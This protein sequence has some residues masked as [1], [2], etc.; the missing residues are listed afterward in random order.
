MIDKSLLISSA[1]AAG[2]KIDAATAEKFDLYARMLVEKNEHVNLTAITEPTEIVQK[3][4]LDSI[5]PLCALEIPQGARVVDV[6]TGAG[7][8]GIPIKLIRPDIELILL[9]SLNKRVEVLKEF[10]E[11]LELTGVTFV[12]A[13]AEDAARGELRESCDVALSR[14]VARLNKLCEYCLPFVKPGGA[15]AALKGPTADEEAKEAASAV[16]L[17]GGRLRPAVSLDIP[18]TALTHRL[19]IVDKI[20]PTPNKYPRQSGQIAKNAL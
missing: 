8:P 3:H 10:C 13:R 9:D 19:V 20:S 14:A 18:G 7:F 17:L 16:R 5:L 2:I 15:F 1:R 12:H 11:K 4:F 6:G